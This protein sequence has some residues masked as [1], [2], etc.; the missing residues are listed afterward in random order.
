MAGPA[1][2]ALITIKP[3]R[4]RRRLAASRRVLPDLVQAAVRTG[5]MR[6]AGDALDR[7]AD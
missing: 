1:W 2:Q 5:D 4:S 7:L 6:M 3:S